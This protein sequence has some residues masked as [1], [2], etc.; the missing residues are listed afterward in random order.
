VPAVIGPAPV[1]AEEKSVG[2]DDRYKASTTPDP[3]YATIPDTVDPT[4]DD[5]HKKKKMYAR[6]QP[7]DNPMAVEQ[8]EISL[9]EKIKSQLTQ[10][11][12]AFKEGAVKGWMMDMEQDAAEMNKDEFIK[13]HGQN[14]ADIWDRVNSAEDQFDGNTEDIEMEQDN[15]PIMING[16]QV[17][18]RSIEFDTGIPDP[19]DRDD[20]K[21][22]AAEAYP[23]KAF[24]MDGTKLSDAELEMLKNQYSDEMEELAYDVIVDQGIDA[25]DMLSDR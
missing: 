8:E 16:K 9:A 20:Q 23:D 7:G 22:R 18:V 12:A 6:S 13:K 21:A 2:E 15:K 17:N 24:F 14:R 25:A 4:S 11:Y 5:L 19:T 1:E 10:D 3:K